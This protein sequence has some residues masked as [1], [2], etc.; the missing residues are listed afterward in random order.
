MAA[1][2]QNSDAPAAE[3]NDQAREQTG[4]Q[5]VRLRINDAEVTTS[6]ANAFRTN[7]TAEEVAIDFGLN[8][9]MPTAQSAQQADGPRN[10]IQFNIDRR[11]VM[12]YYTA[13]RLALMLGQVVRRHEEQFGELKL[14][15]AERTAQGSSS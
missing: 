13:K 8:L 2:Q 12:N 7:T 10:E 5:Q 1:K 14:N 3:V 9:V 15:A 4:Q 6:Y 11:V